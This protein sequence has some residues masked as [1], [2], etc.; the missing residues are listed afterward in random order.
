MRSALGNGIAISSSVSDL[1]DEQNNH[2]TDSCFLKFLE[3]EGKI[4]E[5]L[6]FTHMYFSHL[7]TLKA[8]TF[9]G[10]NSFSLPIMLRD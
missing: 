9:H 4:A 7:L 5:L 1:L 8:D 3:A 2:P 10:S 6:Y